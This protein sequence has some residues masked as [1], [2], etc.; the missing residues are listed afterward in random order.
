MNNHNNI[1]LTY[2]S[3]DKPNKVTYTSLIQS[4]PN[5]K[6]EKPMKNWKDIYTIEFRWRFMKDSERHIVEISKLNKNN[7]EKDRLYYNKF[8]EWVKRD[9]PEDINKFVVKEYYVYTNE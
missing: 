2:S 6:M 4:I 3:S 9:I 1:F 7:Q 8:G 5:S